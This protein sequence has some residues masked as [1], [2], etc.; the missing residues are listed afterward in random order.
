MDPHDALE[1]SAAT[2]ELADPVTESSDGWRLA[3][4]T[5]S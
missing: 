5:L 2:A 3:T 1:L 4:D